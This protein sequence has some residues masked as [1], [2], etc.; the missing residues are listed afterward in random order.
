[1]TSRPSFDDRLASLTRVTYSILYAYSLRISV[2]STRMSVS[3]L[4]CRA[5]SD[6]IASEIS[7]P[8][9]SSSMLRESLFSVWIGA[10]S[11]SIAR[12]MDESFVSPEAWMP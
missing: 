3:F 7:R 4:T 12:T 6:R 2:G 1:M 8:S 10:T 9:V 11:S 5:P